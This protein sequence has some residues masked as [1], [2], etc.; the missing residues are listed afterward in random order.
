MKSVLSIP[1]SQVISTYKNYIDV[2]R[3]FQG[4]D[5]LTLYEHE[6]GLLQWDPVIP[7]DAIFYDQLS[8]KVKP[9]YPPHKTEFQ[10]ASNHINSASPILEIGCGSGQFAKYISALNW[11]G[12]DLNESAVN[13]AIDSGFN[14]TCFDFVSGDLGDLPCQSYEFV[15]SFQTIE[16]LSDPSTLF[17]FAAKVLNPGGK[18][19]L[20]GPAHNSLLGTDPCVALNLPPHHL[21][22]W[23]DTAYLRY[24]L[25]FGF[26]C[27]SLIHCPLDSF[28]NN[29]FLGSLFNSIISP[30]FESFPQPIS[31]TLTT[32]FRRLAL[33]PLKPFI[34]STIPLD[35]KFGI[36][37]QSVV[38]I[39]SFE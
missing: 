36:S 13:E 25:Q 1:S 15:V 22:W 37:G 27:D 34:S 10:V 38:A 23:P 17:K 7:G 31:A 3:F 21:T 26:N 39:Y 2:S 35:S 18:L 19:I 29:F 11:Y 12:I 4:I 28:H 20:G 33:L 6:S 24:P 8:K 9:Y 32:L 5:T 14:A 16:H 30:A